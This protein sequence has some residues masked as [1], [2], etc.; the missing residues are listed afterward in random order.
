M[1]DL[2]FL[3]DCTALGT[4][5]PILENVLLALL[6][7]FILGQYMA[8]IYLLTHNGLSYSQTF[9]QSL[10]ILTTIVCLVILVIG[11]NLLTA[12]GLFGVLAIIRFRNVLKD[13]RDTAFIFFALVLG[14][15]TGSGRHLL[16][17]LGALVVSLIMVYL[18]V[19]RFGGREHFDSFLRFLLNESQTD[20]RVLQPILRRHCLS[21]RLVSWRKSA[22]EAPGEVS[23]RLTLRDPLRGGDMVQELEVSLGVTEV[24]LVVQQEQAEV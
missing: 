14:I 16:A 13:T 2:G 6:V 18:H 21:S 8:W 12:F 23:F 24:S 22:G 9:S 3:L 5:G 7:S 4:G 20:L 17:V 15:G 19:T 11:N 10:V 1:N